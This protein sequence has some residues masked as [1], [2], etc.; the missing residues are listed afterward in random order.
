MLN[1]RIRIEGAPDG[2]LS[3][4]AEP[5]G[6]DETIPPSSVMNAVD[7]H[8]RPR[9]MDESVV[10]KVDAHMVYLTTVAEEHTVTG[11]K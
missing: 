3:S 1:D 6:A 7:P 5:S 8:A 4:D 11:P 2:R 9:R 10:A